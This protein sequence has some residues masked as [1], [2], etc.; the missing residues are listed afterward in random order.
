MKKATSS[1]R[2]ALQA[3]TSS[4]QQLTT[5]QPLSLEIR[6][7]ADIGKALEVENRISKTNL[8]VGDRRGNEYHGALQSKGGV[9]WR[10]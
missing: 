2:N 4:L 1:L 8:S 5:G 10:L 9:E 7:S 6:A 3:E